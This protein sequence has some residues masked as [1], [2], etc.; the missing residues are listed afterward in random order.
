MKDNKQEKKKL[1]V[2]D[3]VRFMLGPHRVRGFVVED[4]GRLGI[5]GRHLVR[6]EVPVEPDEPMVF[7]LPA[8]ELDLANEP[9]ELDR[10]L[11]KS[12]ILN[13]LKNGGLGLILIAGMT[14]ERR[15]PHVWLCRGNLGGVTHTFVRKLGLVGGAPIPV[16]LYRTG[17]K[18][19]RQH[20]EEVIAI[21]NQFGLSREE[22]QEVIKEVGTA[23]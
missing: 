17:G 10:P 18:V 12:E 7:T 13:Y 9:D 20:I 21:L 1:H 8:E 4:R 16:G 2:G 5:G 11:E 19:N 15:E 23:S 6:V 22:A 14:R 3:R